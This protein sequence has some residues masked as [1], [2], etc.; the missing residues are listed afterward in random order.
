VRARQGTPM[1]LHLVGAEQLGSQRRIIGRV[2]SARLFPRSRAIHLRTVGPTFS[3]IA[4][5]Y[6]TPGPD[7]PADMVPD[8]MAGA[9]VSFD[10]LPAVI[11]PAKARE[12]G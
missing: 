8:V 9:H 3:L 12:S 6:G 11:E 7:A 2:R 10:V 5:V 1:L 4:L